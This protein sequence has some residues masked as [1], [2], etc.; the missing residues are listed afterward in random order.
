MQIAVEYVSVYAFI[1]L[2]LSEGLYA[3]QYANKN[4]VILVP[5]MIL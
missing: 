2:N 4:F 3:N 1:A 5:F